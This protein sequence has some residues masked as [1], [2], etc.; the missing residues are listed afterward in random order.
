MSGDWAKDS[1][2]NEHAVAARSVAS[3]VTGRTRANHED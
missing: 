2:A 3:A 1:L